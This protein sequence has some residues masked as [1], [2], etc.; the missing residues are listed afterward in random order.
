LDNVDPAA[1]G[2]EPH[3]DGGRSFDAVRGK[4]GTWNVSVAAAAACNAAGLWNSKD[5]LFFRVVVCGE[6]LL[7]SSTE[8]KSESN[9]ALFEPP[10]LRRLSRDE[11]L[12]DRTKSAVVA[13]F[14]DMD[15]R[16]ESSSEQS[17][18]VGS[19]SR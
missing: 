8:V 6:V 4:L 7:L 17:R 13:F 18:S 15:E 11:C 1:D 14:A 16:Y 19:S 9:D 5:A 12:N 2:T 3:A 10:L